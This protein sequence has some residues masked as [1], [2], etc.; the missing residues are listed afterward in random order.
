MSHVTCA[1]RKEIWQSNKKNATVLESKMKFT[2]QCIS[3]MIGKSP[4]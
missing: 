3:N 2:Q 4:V 1:V